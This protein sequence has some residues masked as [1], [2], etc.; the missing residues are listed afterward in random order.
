MVSTRPGMAM[1]AEFMRTSMRLKL[2][3]V[4]STAAAGNVDGEWERL[5]AGG[6]DLVGESFKQGFA[7]RHKG[8]LCTRLREG[9]REVVADAA[10]APV[11]R[12][13][14]SRK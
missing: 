11:I 5:T 8:D 3:R 9:Q 7:P 1:P 14:R 13:V 10:E 12:T 2:A 6:G 4:R